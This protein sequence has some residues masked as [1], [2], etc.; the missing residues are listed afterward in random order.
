M[1][2]DARMTEHR[3]E[4]EAKWRVDDD[5]HARLREAL[6]QLGAAHV[7]TCDEMNTMLDTADGALR[8]DGRVL[9]L[10]S[11]A[12]AETLLT[13]KGPATYRVGVK[14]REEAETAVG[15]LAMMLRILDGLGF[16]P[17]LE[18]RKTRETWQLE[19]VLA[20]LDTLD[21]GCF[22]EI[23][24]DDAQVRGV[25]RQLGLEMAQAIEKGY[26]ALM[27]AYLADGRT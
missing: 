23:E 18:Y 10:R 26:P 3:V 13:F 24:G 16:R 8:R 15:D 21:F 11:V 2:Y 6:R 27:R 17:A 12:G 14:S 25:A 22:V 9:R 5:G 19:G 20:A 4:T 1:P 7:S